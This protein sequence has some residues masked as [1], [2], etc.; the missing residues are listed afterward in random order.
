MRRKTGAGFK[1]QAQHRQTPSFLGRSASKT[2]FYRNVKS[3][4]AWGGH[5]LATTLSLCTPPLPNRFLVVWQGGTPQRMREIQSPSAIPSRC[6]TST[7]RP[8][9]YFPQTLLRKTLFCAAG[10]CG[11]KS[12]LFVIQNHTSARAHASIIISALSLP[13]KAFTFQRYTTW[14]FLGKGSA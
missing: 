14:I 5:L 4:S 6:C 9:H 12:Q 2:Y 3:G 7:L 8:A 1:L 11:S 10:I 13:L